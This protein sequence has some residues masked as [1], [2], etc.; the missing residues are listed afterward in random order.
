MLEP[1]LHA[2]EK[3]SQSHTFKLSDLGTVAI[4]IK[5]YLLSPCACRSN[6]SRTFMAS[7]DVNQQ[8]HEWQ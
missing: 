6:P 5:T 1:I 2:Y 7:P 3:L 8:M 4:D